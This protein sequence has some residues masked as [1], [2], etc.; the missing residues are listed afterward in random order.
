M[1][2]QVVIKMFKELEQRIA[3]G[4]MALNKFAHESAQQMNTLVLSFNAVKNLL[5]EKGNMTDDEINARII[6][7]V[8]KVKE[9]QQPKD[10]IIED[11]EEGKESEI[12]E[13]IIEDPDE[14]E[15]SE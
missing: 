6:I 10:E 12:L 9:D 13:E 15:T 1:R 8:E 3:M 4:N 5:V 11:P 7:E 2:D 14:E